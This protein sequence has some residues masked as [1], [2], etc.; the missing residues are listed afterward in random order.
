M[1]ELR[2]TPISEVSYTISSMIDD[3]SISLRAQGKSPLTIT[4]Y[5]MVAR[6][7]DR[8]LEQTGMPRAVA[9]IKREHVESWIA[10]MADKAPAT[11]AKC[12]RSA[13]QLFRWLVEE[14]EVTVSPMVN[15][16]PP[17]VPDKQ[18][19]LLTD[20]QVAALLKA[21]AG[22]HFEGRRDTALVRL[23]LDT[24]CRASEVIGLRVE[25]VDL[26]L[27]TAHVVGKGGYER[28]AAIGPKTCEAVRRYLR[29]RTR[30]GRPKG[31]ALWLGKRGPLTDSGLR[32]LLDRRAADA[33]IAHLHPHMFR[34]LFAHRW[35]SAGGQETDLMM[36]A[37]WRSR[38]MVARYGSSAAAARA[39][40]AHH[41][42]SLGDA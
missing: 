39:I 33:G 14:G 18:V 42:L 28:I 34:H 36:L 31:G 25:D 2:Q 26:V 12:Y 29:T 8:Y 22:T 21:C 13:Q 19:P 17:K 23:L 35:L 5:V 7:L 38:A 27:G 1:T 10:S 32:Q 9:S 15:M 20:D 16:R 11:R 37:G 41:R 4:S 24:G 30:E 40:E 3:W 6:S